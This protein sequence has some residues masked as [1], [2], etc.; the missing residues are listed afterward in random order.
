M[1]IEYNIVTKINHGTD[2]DSLSCANEIIHDIDSK[3]S[4]VNLH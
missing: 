1:Y 2:N 3:Y 4:V